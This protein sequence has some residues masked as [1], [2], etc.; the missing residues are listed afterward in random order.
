MNESINRNTKFRILFSILVKLLYSASACL[1]STCIRYH[2]IMQVIMNRT[3]SGDDSSVSHPLSS[4]VWSSKTEMSPVARNRR[5]KVVGKNQKILIVNACK[6]FVGT[7]HC[8]KTSALHCVAEETGISVCT[9]RKIISEYEAN[10]TVESPRRSR[11]RQRTIFNCLDEFDRNAIRMKV[12]SIYLR[13]E[14]PNLDKVL[15]EINDDDTLPNFSR[16]SL[17]RVLKKLNF[18]YKRRSRDCM[19]IDR[20]D[21]I[22][23]RRNYLRKLRQYRAEGRKIYFTDETWV[24][25]GHTTSKAWVDTTVESAK[26][27]YLQGKSTGP[28]NPTS[29][30]KRL[31]VLHI[32]SETGFVDG[33]AYVFPA[34]KTSDY[35]DEMNGEVFRAWFKGMG[36]SIF[37]SFQVMYCK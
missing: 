2:P 8:N 18:V 19:L 36:M 23:W 20:D 12:H 22:C 27:A 16:T 14:I 17:F 5:A 25:S 28:N 7:Q 13:G 32:S 26:Q 33:G 15:R 24:T 29:K 3:A 1:I 10:G 31:I 35:H 34:S 6:K 4:S 37:M 9:I 11:P 21:I 30:G